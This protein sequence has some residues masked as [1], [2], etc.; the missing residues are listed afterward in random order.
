M[1]ATVNVFASVAGVVITLLCACQFPA[2]E[3]P[4]N[5]D[6]VTNSVEWFS[7]VEVLPNLRTHTPDLYVATAAGFKSAAA[8]DL[9]WIKNND[10]L[11]CQRARDADNACIW[12]SVSDVQTYADYA[13]ANRDATNAFGVFFVGHMQDNPGF[14]IPPRTC[15]GFVPGGSTPIT[16]FN[17]VASAANERYSFIF[18]TDLDRIANECIALGMPA[19]WTKHNF[20]VRVVAHELGHQRAGLTHSNEHPEFHRGTFG[21]VPNPQ[22]DV[23]QT[24]LSTDLMGRDRYPAFDRLDQYPHANDNTSC[25]G[26]LFRWRSITN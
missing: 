22:H 11:I 16:T 17:E 25:Q 2:P 3:P 23:M 12:P 24:A 9:N 8:I 10:G 19:G 13:R 15:P 7:E 26:T 20:L 6:V 1:K 21:S 18:F 5:L 4:P 14:P